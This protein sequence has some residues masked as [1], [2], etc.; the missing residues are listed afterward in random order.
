MKDDGKDQYGEEQAQRIA[1][2]IA[3][4]LQQTLS[5][6]EHDELD[7]WITASDENQRLFEELTDPAMIEKGLKEYDEPNAEA[8]LERIKRKLK[9]ATPVVTINRKRKRITAFS[10]AASIILIAGVF[11]MYKTVIEK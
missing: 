1:Y 10:I 6:K 2:L 9:F 4:F 11:F 7:S 8:A 5:E 3:G